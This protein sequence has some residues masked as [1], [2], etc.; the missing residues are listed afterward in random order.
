[1]SMAGGSLVEQPGEIF[2][3]VARVEIADAV[4]KVPKREALT[5][6]EGACVFDIY[7]EDF[8]AGCV[9]AVVNVHGCLLCVDGRRA[10]RAVRFHQCRQDRQVQ[11]KTWRVIRSASL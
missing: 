10:I 6:E 4:T 5:I 7:L 8:G 2:H 1:M 11:E 9:G 3:G